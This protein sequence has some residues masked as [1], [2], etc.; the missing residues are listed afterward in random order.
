V[1]LRLLGAA[2]QPGSENVVV[3]YAVV[4]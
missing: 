2:S 1:P 3:R 4:S